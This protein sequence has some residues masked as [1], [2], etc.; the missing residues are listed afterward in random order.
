VESE[1][2]DYYTGFSDTRGGQVNGLCGAAVP[3][4]LYLTTGLHTGNVELT[5]EVLDAEPPVG[6]EWEEVVRRVVPAAGR[7]GAPGAVGR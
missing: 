6:D 7:P 2:D 5:V 1:P 4:M 3:G